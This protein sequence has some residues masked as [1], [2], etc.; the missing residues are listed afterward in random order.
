[1]ADKFVVRQKKPDKKEDKSIVMTLRLDRELQE[2]FDSLAAKSDR[3]TSL[4]D[5]L[6]TW[7]EGVKIL[8]VLANLW[9]TDRLWPG[10]AYASWH[11]FLSNLP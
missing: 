3:S 5:F 6:S 8:F 11:L 9:V 4:G 10:E 7:T 2:E 1:M